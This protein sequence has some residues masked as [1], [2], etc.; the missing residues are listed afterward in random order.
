MCNE[1]AT[2]TEQP[3]LFLG[4]CNLM[5]HFQALGNTKLP[6]GSSCWDGKG[7]DG[8]GR[9]GTSYS[10]HPIPGCVV[11]FL[12]SI[13]SC[14]DMNHTSIVLGGSIPVFRRLTEVPEHIK[15]EWSAITIKYFAILV[16]NRRD[17]WAGFQG[18]MVWH[19]GMHQQA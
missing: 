15:C 9:D 1:S 8:T 2:S 12:F 11:F 7:R 5:Q 19:M 14:H 10:S 4:Q 3:K 6:W 13:A 16:H 18:T 17:C